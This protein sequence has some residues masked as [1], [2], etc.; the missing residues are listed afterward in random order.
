VTA[1]RRRFQ[2]WLKSSIGN[3]FAAVLLG[4]SLSFM[5]LVGAGNFAYLLYITKQAALE[6]LNEITRDV[7]RDFEKVLNSLVDDNRLLAANPTILSAVLDARGQETYIY[8]LLSSFKPQDRTPESLCVTDYAGRSI[9]C[10][11]QNLRS[12]H[13]HPWLQKAIEDGKPAAHIDRAID[14]QPKLH[15]AFPVIYAGSGAAEGAIVAEYKLADILHSAIEQDEKF[16]HLHLTGA[17]GDIF[18]SGQ[19]DDIIHALRELELKGA[20]GHLE[21][22][23]SLGITRDSFYAPLIKLMTIYGLMAAL[24]IVLAFWVARRIVPP[25]IARLTAITAQANLV[26]LD[27]TRSFD[28]STEGKDEISQLAQSFST[29]T[30]QL[31]KIN[32]SLESQVEARTKELHQQEAL[33]H[34]IMDAVPGAIFQF[35]MRPDGSAHVP[36]VSQAL[37]EIYE[38]EPAMVKEDATPIFSRVH[39]DDLSAHQ[40][41]IQASAKSMTHW[42]EDFRVIRA[43]GNVAWLHGNALP[44]RD[45]DGSILWHGIITDITEHKR[46]EL[47]LAER[48]AFTKALFLNSYIPLVIM[49]TETGKFIDCNEAAVLIYQLGNRERVLGKTPLDVSAP[50]QYDG[51]LSFESADAHIQASQ[52]DGLHIFEWRHKRPS[53]EIWD[54]EVRLMRF[55]HNGK[56]LLQFSLRDITE[57]KR[58]EAEIWRRANYDALTNLANRSLCRDRLDQAIVQ[59]RRTGH[60]V[61][62]LFIDL[63][64]FKGVNDTLGHAVGDELLIQVARRLESCVREQDTVARFGGDEFVLV[65][66]GLPDAQ[67]LKRVAE[68]VLATLYE[69]FNLSGGLKQISGSIGIAVFPNDAATTDE[70]LNFADQALYESK[71]AGKNR[72]YFH[73]FTV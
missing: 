23:L 18:I 16:G 35:R 6:S 60:K 31:Q 4:L 59:T 8:P 69:P 57:Q 38:V 49:D 2:D 64:G 56:E 51:R 73:G 20:L 29:M 37:Q 3:R 21:L 17:D 53:G 13:G 58:S 47:A 61:G 1:L 72:Y 65:I 11:S 32:R 40:A 36:F 5:L 15:I 68:C 50:S 39:P 30:V 62:A 26:A 42:Q 70:L 12:F 19:T 55:R 43:N 45:S 63:D 10:S 7:A 34:S 41:S 54:A 22:K 46:A 71:R 67:D 25:L 44:Q 14:N 52:T 9:G 66:Q 28:I 24:L 48:E 33:L 27:Q